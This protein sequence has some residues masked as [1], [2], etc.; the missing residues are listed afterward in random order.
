MPEVAFGWQKLAKAPTIDLKECTDH[1]DVSAAAWIAACKFVSEFYQITGPIR[2][3]GSE[4][5]DKSRR[6]AD[7]R[8][9]LAAGYSPDEID[10]PG[11]GTH[12]VQARPD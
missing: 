7:A 2:F 1:F 12:S 3:D 9:L 5:E 8:R 10:C 11:I 6:Y 4:R